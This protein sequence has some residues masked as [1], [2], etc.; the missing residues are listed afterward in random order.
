MAENSDVTAPAADPSA[1]IERRFEEWETI[2][3]ILSANLD[4]KLGGNEPL[5]GLACLIAAR[6]HF[7]CLKAWSG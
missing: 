1:P 6:C 4:Y 5:L 3:A 7:D 2:A